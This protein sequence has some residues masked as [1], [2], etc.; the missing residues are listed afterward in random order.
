MTYF[1]LCDCDVYDSCC[2]MVNCDPY[3]CCTYCCL[4][5]DCRWQYAWSYAAFTNNIGGWAQTPGSIAQSVAAGL[6]SNQFGVETEFYIYLQILNTKLTTTMTS[7]SPGDNAQLIISFTGNNIFPNSNNPFPY[8]TTSQRA[9]P[10]DC[11]CVVSNSAISIAAN[12]GY[13]NGNCTRYNIAG[14]PP[15]LTVRVTANVNQYLA[16]YFPGFNTPTSHTNG[17]TMNVNFYSDSM[18]HFRVNNLPEQFKSNFQTTGYGIGLTTQS[19]ISGFSSL[20]YNNTYWNTSGQTNLNRHYQLYVQSGYSLSQPVLYVSA[21]AP[22]FQQSICSSGPYS[23]CRAYNSFVA[24]RYFLVVQSNTA[25]TVMNLSASL[26]YPPSNDN[27][28]SL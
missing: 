7:T 23:A 19:T 6:L 14:Y 9:A 27:S 10:I 22:E 25:T 3:C 16:C 11:L 2:S 26:N 24:R 1:W 20:H 17:W 12:T 5:C 4:G 21:Y 8:T 28:N 18:N 13:T 15:F